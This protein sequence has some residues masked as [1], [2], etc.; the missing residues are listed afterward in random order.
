MDETLLRDMKFNCD[1]SDAQFWGYYSVCGLLMRYRD[2]FRSEKGFKPWADIKREEIALWIE[3][4]E[5]RWPELEREPFRDLTIGSRTFRPFEVAE[6]N[7]ALNKEGFIY[8]AG[9]SMYMK[10]SFFLAELR[11]VRFVS[12]LTIY[13]SGREQVRDLFTSPAMLQEQAVFLRLEPL[14]VLLLYKHSELNIRHATSLED[15]FAQYGFRHRQIV[16]DTFYQRLEAMT[17]RY[18]EV[19]LLHEIAEA[20]EEIGEWKEILARAGDRQVEHYLRAVKDLIADT[21]DHGPYKK[22]IEERDRG[23]LGLTVALMEGYRRTLFP[24]I[25]EAYADFSLRQDWNALEKA[26][27]TGYERFVR[28]RSQIV[29]IHREKEDSTDFLKVIKEYIRK[30]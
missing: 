23:A 22:I 10:P 18:A 21:S 3:K 25:R 30:A 24:E 9:H 5:G 11:S 16:D 15:A 17:E 19:L 14:M 7:R 12:G 8:G 4:K 6:I 2:L 26:R 1:V 29:T 28:E 13:T 27:Q 20:A